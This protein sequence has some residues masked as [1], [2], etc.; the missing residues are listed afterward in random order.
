M[1]RV[2]DRV[3]VVTGAAPGELML[4]TVE[5]IQSEDATLFEMKV[6]GEQD[7]VIQVVMILDDGIDL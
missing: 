7:Q 5:S 1:G 2:Q 4:P 6:F 3:A